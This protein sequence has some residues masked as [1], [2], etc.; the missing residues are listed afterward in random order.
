MKTDEL[1][2]NFN[3][4]EMDRIIEMS[5][6]DKTPFEAIYFQ[7]GLREKEIIQ[8]M[9]SQLKNSSFKRWR[10]RVNSGTSQKH[11]LKRSSAIQRF[12]SDRQRIISN[13]KISKR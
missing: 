3:S 4:R 11:L 5:W 6:E 13:N 7:F 1:Y 9:R 2:Q 8:I 10:R 12:K